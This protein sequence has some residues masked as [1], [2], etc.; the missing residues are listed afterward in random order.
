[1]NG[2]P[3]VTEDGEIVYTFSELQTSAQSAA[4]AS[5]SLMAAQEGMAL[6]RANL[7]SSASTG[8]IKRFL[9]YNGVPTQG[10]LERSALISILEKALPPPS[11]SEKGL[12]EDAVADARSDAL[13]EREYKFSVAPDL[14]R[15]LAGGLG[16]VNLGGALYLGNLL[17][18]YAM[19]GVRLPSYMGLVQQLYP[20]L[21]AYAVLFNV[22][23]AAR[24]LWI[25]GKNGQIQN[26]NG[27]RMQ[28]KSALEAASRGGGRLSRKLQAA[29]GM[30]TRLRQVGAR[31]EDIL[32]DTS[33]PIQDIEDKKNTQA[34]EDFDKLLEKNQDDSGTNAFQ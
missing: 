34:L 29:S 7:P 25:Q 28:W 3:Q 1:L 18:Q 13:Q 30:G 10:A 20:L 19:Y 4:P 24:A 16:V 33:K 32:F 22:I 9:N 31:Q 2:E 15:F 23:P 21:L 26:R 8:Q 6:R 27:I 12:L 5:A 17:G 14:N 11:A